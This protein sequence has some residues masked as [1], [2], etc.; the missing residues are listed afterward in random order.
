M[1]ESLTRSVHALS[2]RFSEFQDNI[3]GRVNRMQSEYVL[4]KNK[5]EL[6]E[7]S[8]NRQKSN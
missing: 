7:Q 3:E 4:L 8:H 6:L 5:V 2:S 1:I